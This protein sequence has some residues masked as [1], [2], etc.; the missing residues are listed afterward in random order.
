MGFGRFR[1]GAGSVQGCVHCLTT[2][3]RV[4]RRSG[5]P[6]DR[7]SQLLLAQW[8][9]E[10]HLP[11]LSGLQM[12]ARYAYPPNERGYCGP[13]DHQAL[14]EYR[15]SGLVDTGLKELAA[16]FTGPWPYLKLMA[17]KTGAGGPF[18]QKVVEAYWVGN[19]LLDQVGTIDFGNTVEAT[20]KPRSGSNWMDMAEAIPGGLPHHSF[21]VFVTYPWVGLLNESHR[22]EPLRILDQCRI[23]WGRVET[24]HGDTAVVTSRP[25]TWDGRRLDLGPPRPETVT[26]AADGLGMTESLR[27][28]EW[29]SMH[30]SWICDR[31]DSRQ[32]ADLEHYSARQLRMTN[33]DLA[34]P[35]PAQVLG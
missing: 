9:S 15:T 28:G 34:H 5:V 20:F 32:L 16:A 10:M 35:G 3:A 12:F 18:S 2:S 22:G 33:H 6:C 1:G 29:V 25:L 14:L 7:G 26:V 30:W 24:V 31:L 23:R 27:P 4:R 13:N 8:R 11:E 17:E 21:H 19:E